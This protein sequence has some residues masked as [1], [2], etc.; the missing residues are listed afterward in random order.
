MGYKAG[1]SSGYAV[2]NQRIRTNFAQGYVA[3]V[4]ER[5]VPSANVEK[6]IV[7]QRFGIKSGII[8]N[9]ANIGNGDIDVA[10]QQTIRN[11]TPIHLGDLIGELRVLPN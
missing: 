2:R 6:W 8:I 4:C 11:F 1:H 10:S 9:A 5:V 7:N 3:A